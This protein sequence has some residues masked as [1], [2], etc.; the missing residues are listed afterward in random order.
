VKTKQEISPSTFLKNQLLKMNL[1]AF[2]VGAR[3]VNACHRRAVHPSSALLSWA[4]LNFC[5]ALYR[6]ALHTL[7]S[8]VSFVEDFVT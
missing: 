1:A 5:G 3:L 8:C 7:Q 4:L 6:V 2:Q